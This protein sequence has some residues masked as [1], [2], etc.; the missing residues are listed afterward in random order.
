MET[1]TDKLTKI[2]RYSETSLACWGKKKV[3]L[4]AYIIKAWKHAE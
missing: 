2:H 1:T 4:I 3:N